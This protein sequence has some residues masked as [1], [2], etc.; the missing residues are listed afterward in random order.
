MFNEF[1]S[2]REGKDRQQQRLKDAENYKLHKELGYDDYKL[3]RWALV[4]IILG[5]LVV[6]IVIY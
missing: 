2:I 3:A 4:L 1:F 6:A 5:L